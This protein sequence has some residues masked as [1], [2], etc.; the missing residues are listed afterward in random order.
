MFK[1]R[2][3]DNMQ[4]KSINQ[5]SKKKTTNLQIKPVWELRFVWFGLVW[6]YGILYVI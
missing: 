3:K 2:L 5:A 1:N 4:L 6:F